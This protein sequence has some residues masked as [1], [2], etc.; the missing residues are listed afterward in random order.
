MGWE[1]QRETGAS[2]AGEEGVGAGLQL[3]RV[4]KP[5]QLPW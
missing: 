4:E 2:E 1:V 5:T 3:H